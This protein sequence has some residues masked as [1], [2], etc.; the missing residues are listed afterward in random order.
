M[1]SYTGNGSSTGP[2]VDLGFEPQW[3][4]T[5]NS[6]TGGTG[7]DWVLVDNKRGVATGGN[8]AYLFANQT[9]TEASADIYDFNSTG[10]SV[11][12]SGGSVN[13]SGDTHIYMA[14]RRGGMQTPTAAS[15]VFDVKTYTGSSNFTSFSGLSTNYVDATINFIRSGS[16]SGTLIWSRLTGEDSLKTASTAAEGNVSDT[17]QWDFT[18]NKLTI[19]GGNTG[20]T[21]S[22]YVNYFLN[23]PKAFLT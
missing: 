12:N 5:K 18:D 17:V 4:L 11:K 13:G 8:D 2:T 16:G 14:I 23:E 3:L 9:N 15:S 22:T 21:G 7:K 6:T 19:T 10:F 20:S 1:W